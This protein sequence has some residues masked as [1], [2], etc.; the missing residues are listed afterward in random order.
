MERYEGVRRALA[1]QIDKGVVW[2]DPTPI[3][4]GHTESIVKQIKMAHCE[5]YVDQFMSGKLEPE[6]IRK[7]GFPWSSELVAR[8][9]AITNG[10]VACALSVLQQKACTTMKGTLASP[11]ACNL[12]G[13][14]HH[15]FREHGEGYCI[16]N[17]IS[18][19][20][21]V[22][23][24]TTSVSKVFVCDLD[25]HQGNGTAQMFKQHQDVFTFSM[26]ADSN[27]PW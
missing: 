24:E 9:M 11:V 14:T 3:S 13:G 6:A 12:A 15:A 26:H 23:L 19:A 17:D 2:V 8:T 7:I 22:A 20:A 16:F 18:V 25:V 27:Y 1:G 5:E 10:T 4:E 21:H